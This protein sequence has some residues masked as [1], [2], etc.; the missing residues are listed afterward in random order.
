MRGSFS[1]NPKSAAEYFL[2]NFAKDKIKKIR[3][4]FYYK[5]IELKVLNPLCLIFLDVKESVQFLRV[6]KKLNRNR[7]NIEQLLNKYRAWAEL[8]NGY[9]CSIQK[10]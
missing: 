10:E 5:K 8:E 1:F 3:G 6:E 2:R 4:E 9:L 7:A